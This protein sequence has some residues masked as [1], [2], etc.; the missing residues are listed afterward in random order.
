[1]VLVWQKLNCKIWGA[2]LKK[3]F[4]TVDSVASMIG[5]SWSWVDK[6]IREGKIEVVWLGG[7]RK[8]PDRE[9]ERIKKEGIK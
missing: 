2:K 3:D 1:M 4:Y 5:M 8:I 7:S 6:K 9:I